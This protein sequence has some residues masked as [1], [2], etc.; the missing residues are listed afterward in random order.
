MLKPRTLKILVALLVVY[1]LLCVPAYTGPSFLE[2]PSSYF[3]LVPFLSVYVFHRLGV[4]G[5]LQHGGYCGSGLCSPT[6]FG[7]LFLAV[8]W[9]LLAWLLAWGL[10]RLTRALNPTKPAA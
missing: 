10:A 6:P 9:I 2:G 4:P 5:L 3:V 8:F 7:W 1:G